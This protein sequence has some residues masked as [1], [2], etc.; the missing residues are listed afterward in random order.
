METK[1]GIQPSSGDHPTIIRTWNIIDINDSHDPMPLPNLHGNVQVTGSLPCRNK[2]S[3]AAAT[4]IMPR[5]KVFWTGICKL[6]GSS[7]HW[8]ESLDNHQI[9]GGESQPTILRFRGPFPIANPFPGPWFCSPYF[10]ISGKNDWW[11]PNCYFAHN[12]LTIGDSIAFLVLNKV[13]PFLCIK[14]N[15]KFA[16]LRVCCMLTVSLSLFTCAP[17]WPT[18]T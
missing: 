1:W 12:R 13:K 15:F 10:E 11:S 18:E 17:G 3:T 9:T 2:A 6:L 5:R 14:N 7:L 16:Q 4:W 8:C